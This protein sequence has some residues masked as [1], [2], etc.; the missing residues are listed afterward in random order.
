MLSQWLLIITLVFLF[1]LLLIGLIKGLIEEKKQRKAKKDAANDR[2]F[3]E[4]FTRLREETEAKRTEI[5][6]TFR[7]QPPITTRTTS[8]RETLYCPPIHTEDYTTNHSQGDSSDGSY[9]AD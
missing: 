2:V 8:T 6:Q 9:S 4:T 7:A 5:K 1:G 3:G